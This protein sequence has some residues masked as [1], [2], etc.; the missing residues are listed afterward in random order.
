MSEPLAKGINILV[1]AQMIVFPNI[2]NIRKD[3]VLQLAAVSRSKH[4]QTAFHVETRL[5]CP[6]AKHASLQAC[7][8][9]SIRKYRLRIGIG[10]V[11]FMSQLCGCLV[12][13]EYLPNPACGYE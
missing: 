12:C 8:H 5:H 1:K 13:V 2:E 4:A 11:H 6:D 7:R 3:N 9:W 10:A